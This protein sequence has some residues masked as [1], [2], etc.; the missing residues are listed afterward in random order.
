MS[1]KSDIPLSLEENDRSGKPVRFAIAIP[2]LGQV[3]FVSAA[4]RSLEMQSVEM[5]IAI[6]DATPGEA[7][8]GVVANYA[9]LPLAYIRHGSD[10]GQAAAIQEGWEHTQGEILGWLNAD[11][12]L[13]PESLKTV[14]EVFAMKGEIDVVYGDAIFVDRGGTFRSYF[15]AISSDISNI[16][17]S[18][19]IAQPA[20]FVRRSA[21]ERIGGISTDLTYIMDW[22]LWT[23]L[24]I[25]GAR[26][27]Y[28][29]QPLAV[30]RMYEETK[31]ASGSWRRLYEIQSHLRRYHRF[32]RL[33]VVTIALIADAA[34]KGSPYWQK[35]LR[36]GVESCRRLKAK[37][38]GRLGEM[39]GR[40]LYGI[41]IGG[42]RVRSIAEVWLP[43]LKEEEP[44]QIVINGEFARLTI[45]VNGTEFEDM[46][47]RRGPDGNMETTCSIPRDCRKSNLFVMKLRDHSE[48]PWTLSSVQIV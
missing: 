45:E 35:A 3:E 39:K 44:S 14:E 25:S 8:Q 42:D 19:C 20:C 37:W 10:G 7:I 28:V 47:L 43:W 22:D 18:C 5:E 1:D 13:I 38:G 36:S 23:R 27:F 32:A 6:L 34:R 11:D 2:V 40:E 29:K 12:Y 21:V 17:A 33:V 41:D 46:T 16:V 15:P 9:N 24:F 26:F 30:V 4:L 48:Q 31:T